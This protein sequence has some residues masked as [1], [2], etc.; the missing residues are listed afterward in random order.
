MQMLAEKTRILAILFPTWLT[1]SLIITLTNFRIEGYGFMNQCT[2]SMGECEEMDFFDPLRQR[3]ADEFPNLRELDVTRAKFNPRNNPIQE[4]RM[5]LPNIEV[6][7]NLQ[8]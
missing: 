1:S 6:I 3:L 7:S 8:E 2:H 4:L 5:E